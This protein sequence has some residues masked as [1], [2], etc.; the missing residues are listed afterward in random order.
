MRPE[1]SFWDILMLLL[2]FSQKCYNSCKTSL[3][4]TFGLKDFQR[5]LQLHN[6]G[7]SIQYTI[8]KISI[9]CNYKMMFNDYIIVWFH[10]T[11]SYLTKLWKGRYACAAQGQ[12]SIV[13]LESA[14]SM[15]PGS[16]R[17]HFCL[18]WFNQTNNELSIIS[19]KFDQTYTKLSKIP[20]KF[21]QTY[22]ELSIISKS[23]IRPTLS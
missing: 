9:Q 12:F 4:N 7:T 23:S 17:S 11:I 15:D 13:Q 21:D 20:E 22:T 18:P 8:N 16:L 19:E 2:I 5:K 10:S 3:H 1:F 6:W 14:L